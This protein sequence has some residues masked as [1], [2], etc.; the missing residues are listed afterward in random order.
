MTWYQGPDGS[1]SPSGR[2]GHT[3]NLVDSK[4]MFVF[5]G[6]DNKKFFQ[7]LY[8]LDLELMSWTQPKTSGPSPSARAQHASL[9]VGSNL[10]VHG[11]FCF[12]EAEVCTDLYS[13]GR[14][15]KNCY[16]SDI[17]ILDTKIMEW[18]R[19]KVDGKPVEPRFGHSMNLSGSDILIF[20]GWSL[21]SGNRSL[22]DQTKKICNSY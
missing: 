14:N 7:D 17:R 16:F 5:G 13:M 21:E 15:L 12:N 8:V 6:R 18:S 22:K 19:L 9:L 1:G 11:G 10:L 2:Y 4:K 20:G 3:A